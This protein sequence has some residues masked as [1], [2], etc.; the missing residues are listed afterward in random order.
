MWFYLELVKTQKKMS[1]LLEKNLCW[2]LRGPH[3]WFSNCTPQN[4]PPKRR[5]RE[6]HVKALGACTHTYLFQSEKYFF[7]LYFFM[8]PSKVSF[9][10]RARYRLLK[11]TGPQDP[12]HGIDGPP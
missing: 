7:F 6:I 3:M 8:L 12:W 4:S 9:E 1:W 5:D 11:T 10:P 2:L